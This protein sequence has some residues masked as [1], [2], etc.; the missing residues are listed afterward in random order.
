[1]KWFRLLYFVA[2]LAYTVHCND[3]YKDVAIFCENNGLIYIT[4]T[5]FFSFMA[6]SLPKVFEAFQGTK[7][8]SRAIPRNQIESS[9]EFHFDDFLLVS[10][11]VPTNFQSLKLELEA[12]KLRK[13]RKSLLLIPTP[14][15]EVSLFE[16]LQKLQGSAFFYLAYPGPEKTEFKQVISLLNNTKTIVSDLRFN[17]FGHIIEEYNLEGSKIF[18]NTRPWAPYFMMDGCNENGRNCNNTGFLAD[19]MDALGGVLNFTW[20][21]HQ[22]NDGRGWGV[23]PIE[24]PFNKSGIWGGAMG[25]VI[26]EEYHMSLSQW[27]WNSDRYELLDFISTTNSYDCLAL[28]PSPPEVDF[29]LFIRPF[30]DDAWHGI[31]VVLAISFVIVMVPYAFLSYYEN[32]DGYMISSTSVWFFFVLINAYYGGALTMF[33]TSEL[34][35]P[36][37]TI[38]DVMRA[39]PDFNLMMMDGNQVLFVYK[40]LSVSNQLLYKIAYLTLHPT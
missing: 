33:F 19:Y 29:G 10:N 14:V 20:D 15:D 4:G 7:I 1:M 39:Y 34:R 35:I 28:T 23:T 36:F 30:R 9:M 16:E 31:G 27:I 17:Q 11:A 5:T 37:N 40:A 24:G 26:N 2:F 18:S 8:R 3:I 25:S 22:P 13:I 38:H 12:I 32:T 21:S 6:K